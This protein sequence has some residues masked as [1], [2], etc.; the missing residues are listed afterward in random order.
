MRSGSQYRS[1]LWGD[2]MKAVYAIT[3]AALA[4]AAGATAQ[5]QTTLTFT[6]LAGTY[7]DGNSI[8][9]LTGDGQAITYV[10]SGYQLT[11]HTNN[12]PSAY[13]G[14]HIG[15]AS[16]CDNFNWHDDGDNLTGA[17]VTLTKVGGGAFDLI[18][19]DFSSYY[20]SGL[21]VSAAG[22]G[23]ISLGAY[24]GGTYLADF[25]NI[26]SVTFSSDGYN[27]NVLDNIQLSGGVPEPASWA[28][29]LGG[30]GLVGGALR[31]R[32]KAVS[33]A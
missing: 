23:T 4:L 20:G 5:A 10:E 1:E 24:T 29:M 11:L 28:M 6:G 32:R 27:Y 30:F 26:T 3:A 33:F 14:A 31:S 22:Y 2:F 15:D 16:C 21:N 8:S 12:D 17:Y 25:S 19:F 7:G 9:P 13:F 18:S